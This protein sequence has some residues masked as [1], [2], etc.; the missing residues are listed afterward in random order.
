[1]LGTRTTAML[2]AVATSTVCVAVLAGCG[3]GEAVAQAEKDGKVVGDAIRSQSEETGNDIT[4]TLTE[5]PWEGD[6]DALVTGTYDFLVVNTEDG[7]CAKLVFDS[8]EAG[9]DYAIEDAYEC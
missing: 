6:T 4:T 9:A 2:K 5:N 3:G 8:D 1:M 7:G